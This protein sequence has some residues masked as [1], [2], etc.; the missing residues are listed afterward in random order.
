MVSS[1]PMRYGVIPQESIK[2]MAVMACILGSIAAAI[3]YTKIWYIAN[4][5]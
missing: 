5:N 3:G 1:Y 2:Y 4:E